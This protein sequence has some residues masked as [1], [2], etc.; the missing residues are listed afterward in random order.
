MRQVANLGAPRPVRSSPET[1]CF[2]SRSKTSWSTDTP[3]GSIITVVAVL[4]T[5]ML[6]KPVASM[7]PPTMRT[8]DVPTARTVTSAMR[9]CRP[10]RCIASAIM[11]PPMNRRINSLA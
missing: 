2:S 7:K 3:I 9:R 6:R 11:K 1:S 5:H 8:G 4:L 10:Q